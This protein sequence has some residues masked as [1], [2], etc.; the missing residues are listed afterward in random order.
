MLYDYNTEYNTKHSVACYDVNITSKT[1]SLFS[2]NLS[3][4]YQISLP[5]GSGSGFTI[6]GFESCCGH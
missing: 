4:V 1:K 3:I 6:H 5:N 2:F